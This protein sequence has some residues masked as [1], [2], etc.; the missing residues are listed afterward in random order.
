MHVSETSLAARRKAAGS[1]PRG[2]PDPRAHPPHRRR[3]DEGRA[4]RPGPR[5]SGRR[6]RGLAGRRRRPRG[7][8]ARHPMPRPSDTAP[9]RPRK[10]PA[11]RRNPNRRRRSAPARRRK[12]SPRR[13]D[14]GRRGHVREYG[15]HS[16]RGRPLPPRSPSGDKPMTKAELIERVAVATDVTKKQAEAIVDT[17]FDAIVR[18]LKDGQKIELRGLRLV[19]PAG[20]GRADGPQPEDRSQGRRARQEDS[21]FQAR[22]RAEGADQPLSAS[23]PR[24][25]A[26]SPVRALAVRVSGGRQIGNGCIFCEAAASERRG[27]R[28]RR[29]PR[30]K[31]LRDPEPLS[32]HERTR[33]GRALRARG[34]ALGSRSRN[35]AGAH[36]DGRARG[37]RSS[38]RPTGPT[39]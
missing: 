36:R 14:R 16:V 39:A 22:Q 30:P 13:A 11:P 6:R 32:L 10:P 8:R 24:P 25:D 21:V 15:V 18:S 17:V 27:R 19:P 3:R 20:T 34:V 33:H 5:R 1:L 23:G 9:R 29:L 12:T 7:S 2:G 37:A 26:G 31:G 38:S 28:A 4:V 35:A